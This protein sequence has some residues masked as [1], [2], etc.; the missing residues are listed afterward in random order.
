VAGRRVLVPPPG[1]VL[2]RSRDCDI[3]LE[4]PGVSRRHAEIR[5]TED[6]WVLADLGSTNGVRV[7]GRTL[8]GKHALQ[9]GDR[10]EL[11]HTE[12]VFDVR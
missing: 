9:R 12:L 7:N 11:G 4:D 8:R 2:G 10:I 5:P 1:A 3:V 6:D